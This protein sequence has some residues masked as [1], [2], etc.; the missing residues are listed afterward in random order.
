MSNPYHFDGES[1]PSLI[2]S[3]VADVP[4]GI[5]CRTG[6]PL[7]KQRP[8]VKWAKADSTKVRC[9]EF[10]RRYLKLIGRAS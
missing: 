3:V 8:I 10:V 1:L 9:R 2:R 7:R 6:Q 4:T 5:D